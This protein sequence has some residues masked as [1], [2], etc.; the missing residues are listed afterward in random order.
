MRRIDILL[1]GWI[2]WNFFHRC[3]QQ[4]T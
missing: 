3:S 4:A 2:D 1:V